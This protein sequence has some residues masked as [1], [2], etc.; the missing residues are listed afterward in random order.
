MSWEHLYLH[1]VHY[2]STGRKFLKEVSLHGAS[3]T[4]S[5]I[6]LSGIFVK[7]NCTDCILPAS[8]QSPFIVG[9]A[10]KLRGLYIRSPIHPAFLTSCRWTTSID[11]SSTNW[12]V[13]FSFSFKNDW[14]MLK[15][16]NVHGTVF[17]TRAKY[18]RCA[19]RYSI[20]YTSTD[21]S[22]GINYPNM[23]SSPLVFSGFHFIDVFL[24]QSL[25][26]SWCATSRAS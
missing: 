9:T 18:N 4:G 20:F 6:Q 21:M 5:N 24:C 16:A 19:D 22:I 11:L 26:A 13:H 15:Y 3:G 25:L 12:L 14:R 1:T 17:Y 8:R 2:L 23:N 10:T 7:V